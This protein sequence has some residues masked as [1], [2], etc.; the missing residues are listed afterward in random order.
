MTDRERLIAWMQENDMN[1]SELARRTGD[2]RS[3]IFMMTTGQREVNEAFKWRFGSA[4]GFDLAASIFID[5]PLEQQA[6]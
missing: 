2:H 4:F 6:V 1:G 5:Q 3:A